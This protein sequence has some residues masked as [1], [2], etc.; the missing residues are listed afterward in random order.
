MLDFAPTHRS[1]TLTGKVVLWGMSPSSRPSGFPNKLVLPCPTTCSLALPAC[2]VVSSRSLDSATLEAVR[3]E[4]IDDLASPFEEKTLKEDDCP[5]LDQL[6]AQADPV[7][8]CYGLMGGCLWSAGAFSRAEACRCFAG[9]ALLPL[10]HGAPRP[11]C[12]AAAQQDSSCLWKELDRS[13]FPPGMN[14]LLWRKHCFIETTV[15][16]NRP[17]PHLQSSSCSGV[18]RLSLGREDSQG[19][20]VGLN[21]FSFYPP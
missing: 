8:A 10:T 21:S 16:L 5:C 14:T 6:S 1:P 11:A 7:S 18:A 17:M 13:W 20:G 12:E 15:A 4:E 19:E 2:G 3:T 9:P